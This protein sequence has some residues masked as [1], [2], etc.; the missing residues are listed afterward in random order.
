MDETISTAAMATSY[1]STAIGPESRRS[2]AESVVSYKTTGFSAIT[3]CRRCI[4]AG[5]GRTPS[6]GFCAI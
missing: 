3:A 6:F 5:I 1:A 2:L 4:T